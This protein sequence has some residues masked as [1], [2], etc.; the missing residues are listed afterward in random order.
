[1]QVT[2]GLLGPFSHGRGYQELVTPADPSAGHSYTLAVNG[3]AWVRLISCAFNL[4]TSAVAGNRVVTVQYGD[5]QGHVWAADGAGVLVTASSSAQQFYGS[6]QRTAGEW[7]TPGPV[8]FPLW[9]GF[10]SPGSHIVLNVANI[11]G[12]DQL[13]AIVLLLEKFQNDDTGYLTGGLDSETF[14]AWREHHAE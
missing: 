10:M 9:G 2:Y 7:Q 12:T 4:T 14:H 5:P 13:D 11:D 6:N 3:D 8:F 1:M